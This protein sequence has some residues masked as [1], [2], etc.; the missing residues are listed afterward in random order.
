VA[1][2]LLGVDSLVASER[3]HELVDVERALGRL[4]SGSYGR[5]AVCG[6]PIPL[7][8]L[9]VQPTARRCVSC[10][11]EWERRTNTPG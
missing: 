3:T 7:A 10:K 6:E 8:R 11:A 9:Q 5:C 1:E 4:A 2:L